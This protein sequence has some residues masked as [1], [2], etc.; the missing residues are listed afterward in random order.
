MLLKSRMD[1]DGG[2]AWKIKLDMHEMSFEDVHAKNKDANVAAVEMIQ[3][4]L[5][6]KAAVSFF[7]NP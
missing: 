7:I 6:A 2:K 1:I 4:E 3:E 5:Y